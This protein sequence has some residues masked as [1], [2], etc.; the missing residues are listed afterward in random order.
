MEIG[1]AL[2]GELNLSINDQKILSKEAASLG[3]TS[4]WTNEGTGY[5]GFHMCSQRWSA[6]A[7]VVAGG[8]T[9]G[10]A[11]SPVLHRT[12][13]GFA[14][15]AAT[16]NEITDG[17]F[18]LGIG[19]GGAY[20]P[21][22]RTSVGFPD[23]PPIS[24]MRDYLTIIK[25]LLSG[26]E[27]NY[28]GKSMRLNGIKLGLTNASRTPIYAAALGPQMLKLSGELADGVCLN[29][30]TPEQV[31]W[32]RTLVSEGAHR[33]NR[34]PETIPLVSYIRVSVDDNVEKSRRAFAKSLMGYALGPRVPTIEERKQGYRAHFERA[35]FAKNLAYIDRMRESGASTEQIVDAFPSNM[36]SSIGYYGPAK[37]ASQ[38][39]RKASEGLDI[40]IVRVVPTEPGLESI[41][42][43]MLACAPINS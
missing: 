3:Y 20:R 28:T 16:L 2:G 11:V 5:D 17:R 23:S 1:L 12:P 33:A 21:E 26:N 18:I 38:G 43:I 32:S 27:V 7:E 40:G 14:M 24:L 31:S 25:R 10:I 6:T 39:F 29:W 35:G 9:T 8:L 22:S 37:R 13:V 42:N 15:S 19:T 30:C 36:L 41:R 34:D 4:I